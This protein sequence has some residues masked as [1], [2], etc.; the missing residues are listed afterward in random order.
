MDITTTDHHVE[1]VINE[2]KEVNDKAISARF[3]TRNTRNKI[4]R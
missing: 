3:R 2:L 1:V 4:I